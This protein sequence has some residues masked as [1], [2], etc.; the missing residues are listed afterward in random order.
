MKQK[1][2]II[3]SIVI[4]LSSVVQSEA[5][6]LSK[7]TDWFRSKKKSTTVTGVIENVEGRKVFFK[8][9]DGQLLELTGKKAEKVAE[10]KGAKIRVFG[11]VRKPDARYPTGG[12]EVRN[13]RILEEAKKQEPQVAQ[14]QQPQMQQEVVQETQP[15]EPEPAPEPEPPKQQNIAQLDQQE[16]EHHDTTTDVET[17][18]TSTTP[19]EH[20][21]QDAQTYVVQKGDTLAKISKKLFGTTKYWKKIAKYNNIN[22]P[23]NLKVGMTLKIPKQ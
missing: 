18:M 10:F 4:L 12:L 8:T 6:Y 5:G 1:L 17:A 9:D 22:N 16:E 13:Y 21:V 23:K 14:V 7:M 11:N 2:F 3:V 19:E 15:V 20:E